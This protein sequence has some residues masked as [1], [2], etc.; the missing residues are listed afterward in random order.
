MVT[1]NLV[2]ATV[3]DNTNTHT[4]G[5][6]PSI[7]ISLPTLTASDR[8][9][10]SRDFR[11]F[12]RLKFV[13]DWSLDLERAGEAI[14]RMEA[15][16][17]YEAEDRLVWL[18]DFD[19]AKSLEDFDADPLACFVDENEFESTAYRRRRLNP[20]RKESLA[21][22]PWIS[23]K[24]WGQQGDALLAVDSQFFTRVAYADDGGVVTWRLDYNALPESSE[25]RLRFFG[26]A[27]HIASYAQ[28]HNE[29]VV[30]RNWPRDGSKPEVG[31]VE[32][33]NYEPIHDADGMVVGLRYIADVPEDDDSRIITAILMSGVAR[34]HGL[35]FEKIEWSTW[36]PKRPP[37]PT[38]STVK[39]I[40]AWNETH[41]DHGQPTDYLN[42]YF[43]DTHKACKQRMKSGYADAGQFPLPGAT[44]VAV[45]NG[46]ISNV[47][48]ED[49]EGDSPPPATYDQIEREIHDR[50]AGWPRSAYGHLFIPN[51]KGSI[52][53]FGDRNGI[54]FFGW[55]SAVWGLDWNSNVQKGFIPKAEFYAEFK[56]RAR[57]YAAI[58]TM[59]HAPRI[60]GHF[61]ACQKIE[62]SDG[63][64]FEELLDRFIPETPVDRELIRCMFATVL[65]GGPYGKRP[66]FVISAPRGR[67]RGKS[68]LAAM[69]SEFAGG[70]FDF[71]LGESIER[72]KGRM[73]T[74]GATYRVA[75]LDNAKSHKLSWGQLESLITAPW[76]SGHKY[77]TGDRRRPNTFV[78][79]ITANAPSMAVD[80]A[81]RCVEIQ[82]APQTNS[83]TWDVETLDFI[84]KNRLKIAADLIEWLR[85]QSKT[86]FTTHSRWAAWEGSVLS[87]S[88]LAL[89]CQSVILERQKSVDV[90]ADEASNLEDFFANQLHSFGYD[91][92]TVEI[93]IGNAVAARWYNWANNTR[94]TTPEVLQ[95]IRQDIKEGR[96]P[97]MSENP[98]RKR[99]GRG[100]IWCGEHADSDA[101]VDY[102]LAERIAKSAVKISVGKK[103]KATSD[104]DA[105][106]EQGTADFR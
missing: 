52:D 94:A 82:L 49:F 23:D 30:W 21:E 79:I 18:V 87:K 44:G 14:Q 96:L 70:H 5:Q 8:R 71:S 67:G 32:P 38:G 25:L 15:L 65:W 102:S 28:S 105:G 36:P 4:H 68:T 83:K 42:Q 7:G 106:D 29:I 56:R 69:L 66:C 77:Y 101:T 51:G 78:W 91:P 54:D 24:F 86:E 97:L 72:I 22:S 62:Q 98:S 13:G 45:N 75:V 40:I 99:G 48:W 17:E 39:E 104:G 6:D 10:L 31:T 46:R 33:Q 50:S 20:K 47:K 80:L 2:A 84:R 73:L 58:E 93:H 1:S 61:Y 9:C 88:D 12:Y 34:R 19:R 53:V 35:E 64:A 55:L 100:F 95:E 63:K 92:D 37:V 3:S 43:A 60:A 90:D 85:K 59:P 103:S 76:I 74:D 41:P 89:E 26:F 81:Q 16:C 27:R 57:Q 11:N